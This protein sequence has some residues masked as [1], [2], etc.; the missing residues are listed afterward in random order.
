M[1]RPKTE[2]FKI[3]RDAVERMHLKDVD[4]H[5]ISEVF[6]YLDEQNIVLEKLHVEVERMM[7]FGMAEQHLTRV[8]RVID[9]LRETS[10][11]DSP[12]SEMNSS[13]LL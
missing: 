9:S 3:A 11:R 13:M 4:P 12:D 6:R 7:R 2:K 5:H 1:L 10:Q 8:Q